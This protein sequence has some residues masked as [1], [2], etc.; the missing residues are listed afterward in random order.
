MNEQDNEG[1]A[2]FLIGEANKPLSPRAAADAFSEA[3][4]DR[5]A[6]AVAT[7]DKSNTLQ[8]DL[9]LLKIQFIETMGL[10]L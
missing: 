3:V 4:L 10:V 1:F 6:E 2:A 8:A 9:D 5:V 7:G